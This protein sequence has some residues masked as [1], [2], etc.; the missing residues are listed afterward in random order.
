MTSPTWSST[1]ARAS[2]TSRTTGTPQSWAARTMRGCEVPFPAGDDD[3]RFVALL[4]VVAEGAREVGRVH[5]DDARGADVCHRRLGEELV[6]RALARGLLLRIALGVLVLALHLVLAH[7]QPPQPRASRDDQVQHTEGEPHEGGAPRE[8]AG[9][10]GDQGCDPRRAPAD[11]REVHDVIAEAAHG[12]P[13]DDDAGEERAKHGEE[14]RAPR[15]SPS[16][17]RTGSGDR[18]SASG[19]ASRRPRPSGPAARR[20][21]RRPPRGARG[22]RAQAPSSPATSCRSVP[23]PDPPR[24]RWRRGGR[25]T[26]SPRVRVPRKARPPPPR[27]TRWPAPRTRSRRCPPP[28]A[29]FAAAVGSPLRS[30]RSRLLAGESVQ[31]EEQLAHPLA[32]RRR[33]E[34]Q[35]DPALLELLR[36]L[37]VAP[38]ARRAGPPWSWRRSAGASPAPDRTSRAR[39]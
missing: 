3:G 5:D 24:V 20:P 26:R 19:V 11:A 34:L 27:R 12:E 38:P 18:A 32:R 7:S 14:A 13:R 10:V 35:V 39:R 28:R 2:G 31:R 21:R 15:R 36:E 37:R 23:R 6:V 8:G 22:A 16:R 1:R 33:D 4:F 29:P 9:D 25:S 30:C 17:P